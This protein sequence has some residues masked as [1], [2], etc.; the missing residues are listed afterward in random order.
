[1]SSTQPDEND[2]AKA[3]KLPKDPTENTKPV[4]DRARLYTARD[5]LDEAAAA[6]LSS[7]P[8]TYCTTGVH[9]IDR[10]TGGI[11]PGWCWVIGA[12]TN[13]GKST[14]ATMVLDVNM[15]RGDDT[16]IVTAEDAPALYGTR[17]LRRRARVSAERL[18]WRQLTDEEKKRIRDVQEK[19]E[20]RPVLIDAR[21]RTV[22]WI[23][24][25][26]DAALDR[27]PN[28]KIVVADYL[29]DFRSERRHQDRRN[30][31]REISKMLR[32]GVKARGRAMIQLSQITVDD[33]SKMPN[34]HSIRDCRDISN[35][36]EVVALMFM[37]KDDLG[38]GKI[39]AGTACMFLDKVKDGEKSII[40]PLKF[41]KNAQC[42]DTVDGPDS[43]YEDIVREIR[44]GS[45]RQQQR[46][47]GG[48]RRPA[49]QRQPQRNWNEQHED[50]DYG[51]PDGAF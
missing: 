11:Q 16:L 22:E 31:L 27:N 15:N 42:Y 29:Q 7:D 38:N 3:G 21:N 5:L 18:R 44:G 36:A 6:A 10:A 28:I 45:G 43:H 48:A 1:M 14:F 8:I 17:L 20:R 23:A 40:V 51:I 13:V 35:G 12:D 4:S 26:V 49:Q 32:E 47:G 30:E 34:K 19:A 37:A 50:D 39:K 2:L 46:G 24:R 41:D 25:E 9:D 33:E